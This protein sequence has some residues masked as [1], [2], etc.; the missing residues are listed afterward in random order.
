MIKKLTII[1]CLILALPVLSAPSTVSFYSVSISLHQDTL[2]RVIEIRGTQGSDRLLSRIARGFNPETQSVTLERAA[3]GIPDGETGPVPPWAV[4]TLSGSG[5]WQLTL[6]TAFPSLREGMTIDYI[7]SIKDW[8]G[9]WEEGIW[10]VLSPLIKGIRPDTCLFTVSGDLVEKLN[11]QGRGYDI[12]RTSG[13]VEFFAS[14]SSETLFISPF[15]TFGELEDFIL[16]EATVILDSSYPLDLREAALQA[17]SAGAYQYAQSARARSLLCNSI[18]LS[19]IMFGRDV[20]STRS[21]Q[22]ILD[23]RRGTALEIALV[24]TAMCRELGI[25]ANIL[26]ACNT[27]YGI[28]VPEGWNRYLVKLVTD[29]GDEWFMEPSAYLTSA[30]YIYRPDTLY[31]IE[32]GDLVAIPPNESRDNRI[33]EEWYINC[34]DGTFN[35]EMKCSGW[36]D[37]MLRRRLAGLSREEQILSVSQWSWLS[38]R[39]VIPDS[40]ELS[41]PFDLGTDMILSVYGNLWMPVENS[42]ITEYLPVLNWTKPENIRNEVS[43]RWILSGISILYAAGSPVIE[44]LSDLITLS[45]TSE[46]ESP[47]PVVFE[48]AE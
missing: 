37:M 15:S 48:V 5:G 24:F 12:T 6:V 34:V 9:N 2:R 42:T 11:W 16:Q 21:L 31:T 20:Y 26:P 3:F 14:D 36:Y 46:I 41:D 38:G 27:D 30:S 45:D 44:T 29:D 40:L 13:R 22:E 25:E 43:R 35:L 33:V 47:L 8:S 18:S 19:P 1:V 10:A 17:T 7:V 32:N 28:P 4:D 23:L 39:T